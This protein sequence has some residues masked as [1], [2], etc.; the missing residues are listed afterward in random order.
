MKALFPL[1]RVPVDIGQDSE[2]P[3]TARERAVHL[4]SRMAYGPRAGDIALV[5]EMG[6]EAWIDAP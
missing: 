1:L 5:L 6:E 4:L 2:S 3:L